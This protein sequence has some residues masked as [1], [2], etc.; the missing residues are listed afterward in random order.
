MKSIRYIIIAFVCAA[1]CACTSDDDAPVRDMS[2]FVYAA[3]PAQGQSSDVITIQG[4]NFSGIRENNEVLFNDQPAV[5]IEARSNELQ[6]VVPE[7]EDLA[8][9]RVRVSGVEA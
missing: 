5:V 1:F 7:G 3:L 8:N 9:V 4:K 2:P 6:V